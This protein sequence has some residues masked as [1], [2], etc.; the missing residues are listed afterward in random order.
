MAHNYVV[1]DLAD[2]VIRARPADLTGQPRA[3]LKRN[4]LDSIACAVGSLDGE[5]IPTLREHTAR[6]GGA[7]TATL[8]GGGRASVDQ[9][10]FFNAVL[11]RYPDLLDTYLTVGGLCHPADNIG[12]I[13]AVA[14]HT[15]A[16]G[17]DFLLALAVAYEI[18]CRFSA[19]V[20][21]M[22][23][24]LNHAL[25]LSMSVAAGSAKLLGLSAEQTANAIAAA[26]ADNV[27]LA[28]VHAE[29]VSNWKGISPAITGMRAV[30]TTMLAARGITGP[31]S[32]FE[33]PHGLVQLFDQP[34]D[35][36]TAD[37]G[38]TCVE[39]T[40][41]KQYCSLIHG[42]VVIDAVL[43]VRSENGLRGADVARVVLE[44]FQGAY[45]FAG[46]GAYGDKEH[47]I[48]KEQADYNLKYLTAVALIDGGVGPEQLEDERVS[49]SDVQEL[50]SRV[51]V[52]PAADLTADYPQ[53]T[54]ARVH[55]IVDDGREF[56]REQS[57]YEGSP[58][59]P[60]SWERVVDK[61]GWL[62]EPFCDAPLR[63]DIVAAVSRLDEIPITGLTGL[64]GSV[65]PTA[66]RARSKPRF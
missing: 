40:Y 44:V 30:Y 37:R 66:R 16:G 28:T 31:K 18:Q 65:L 25:Q 5:L 53:R 20:P 4:V 50:L 29:P 10:A 27:S 3:L 24:G 1:D 23:R 38:L 54:A 12:A 26:A 11:V 57:D 45:D 61:F 7:P 41:L 62:A 17:D 9:A 47:P 46:G 14:E 15:G 48:T 21:V 32:L 59:R 13:L 52:K 2:F 6:F 33:G 56:S 43:A 39:Q 64:L 42:Q 19:Q 35:L 36:R 51:E 8:V 60:M 22:A 58:T 49:R 34:I 63:A 55:V